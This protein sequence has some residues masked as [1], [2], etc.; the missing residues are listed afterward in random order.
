MKKHIR[1]IILGA[2]ILLAY[3]PFVAEVKAYTPDIH[4]Y[5]NPTLYQP[6]RV[7]GEAAVYTCGLPLPTAYSSV[8]QNYY[9]SVS[10]YQTA[11]VVNAVQSNPVQTA[12]RLPNTGGGGKALAKALGVSTSA[13]DSFSFVRMGVWLLCAVVSLLVLIPLFLVRSSDREELQLKA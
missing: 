1:K 12:P 2:V 3:M 5:E 13:S 6:A 7:A 8:A 11:S 10:N 9:P 4:C